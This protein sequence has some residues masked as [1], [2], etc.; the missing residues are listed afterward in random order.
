MSRFI[1]SPHEQGTE[2]WHLARLGKV[3]GSNCAAIFAN[4]RGGKESDQRKKLKRTLLAERLTGAAKPA[5]RESRAIVWGKEQ[6]A[7]SRMAYELERGIDVDQAGFAYLPSLAAGCSVD[8]FIREGHRMG[9]WESKSPD[10]D[11]HLEYLMG[12]VLPDEYLPQVRHNVWVTG[13]DFAD[14]Q[15]FDPRMP[16]ELQLFIVRVERKDLDIEGHERSVLQ[17][18]LELEADEKKLRALIEERRARIQEF[19]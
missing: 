18:L 6:E 9:I 15:S 2:G 1:V 4:G 13:A 14:F 12:G 19:A 10:Q 16:P 5:F 17:F 7:H 3:T 8:G 11:T